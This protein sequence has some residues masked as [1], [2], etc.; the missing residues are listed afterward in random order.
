[1]GIVYQQLF[2]I[3]LE[4]HTYSVIQIYLSVNFCD[5]L[6]WQ[7]VETLFCIV[8]CMAS[9]YCYYY[10]MHLGTSRVEPAMNWCRGVVS[11][12]VVVAWAPTTWVRKGLHFLISARKCV[13]SGEKY[14]IQGFLWYFEQF[15]PVQPP[16]LVLRSYAPELI[17]RH[18]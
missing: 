6:K 9:T 4:S 10:Y 11:Y 14:E 13:K 5:G 7:T 8:H 2:F 18:S 3:S 15:S 16:Q 17:P 1:M 12:S